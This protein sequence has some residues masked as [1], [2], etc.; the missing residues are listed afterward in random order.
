MKEKQIIN[1]TTNRAGHKYVRRLVWKA[2]LFTLPFWAVIVL[3]LHDDP[4]MVE[5]RYAVYDSDVTL[6]EHHVGWSIYCNR[7]DSLPFNSFILGNSCTMA[8][9][10]DEWEKYLERDARAVRL[11][12]NGEGLNAILLK[13]QAL[14]RDKAEIRNVL[15]ILDHTSLAKTRQSSGSGHILPAEISGCSSVG[16]QLEFLQA[17]VMPDFLFPYLRYKVTGT[18][19]PSIKHLNPYGRVRNSANNDAINPRERMIEREG[20]GYW[21][22]RQQEFP[23]RDGNAVVSD[24]AVFQSQFALLHDMADILNRNHSRVRILISPDYNQKVLHPK[25]KE[26]LCKL[27]GEENVFDFTGINEYTSDYHYY[28][29]QGH[30]RPLLGKKLME[31]IYGYPL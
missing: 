16:V 11:F 1:T 2:L 19:L 14:E 28:Y 25:D 31:R 18:I 24:R 4:F 22:N 29:E 9:P 3:Y 23:V 8:F 6:N 12:G 26:I 30:Y 27:F 7:R 20:E 21:T 10:C 17:F 15:M 5:H 13:L